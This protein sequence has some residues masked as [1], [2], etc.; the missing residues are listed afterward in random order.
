MDT[1]L[2]MWEAFAYIHYVV[3][4][5]GVIGRGAAIKGADFQSKCHLVKFPKNFL[6]CIFGQGTEFYSIPK[7]M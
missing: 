3:F 5:P 1:I 7:T 4:I 2:A 6:H